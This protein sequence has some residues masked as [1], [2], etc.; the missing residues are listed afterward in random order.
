MSS[1]RSQRIREKYTAFSM[2]ADLLLICLGDA[3]KVPVPRYSIHRMMRGRICTGTF[4]SSGTISSS[5]LV[6][7]IPVESTLPTLKEDLEITIIHEFAHYTAF[8]HLETPAARQLD[9]YKYRTNR[10]YAEEDEILTWLR[11]KDSAKK[12]GLWN[13]TALRM[14]INSGPYAKVLKVFPK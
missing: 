8:V 13:K 7:G 3:H 1:K 10:K 5:S 9:A 6:I 4:L 11:T 14:C 2:Y 12:L